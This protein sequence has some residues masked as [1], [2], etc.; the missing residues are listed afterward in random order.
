MA[1]K[2]TTAPWQPQQ[3]PIKYGLSEAERLY[4]TGKPT[5]YA[6]QTLAGF[7]PAEKR[8]QQAISGYAMGPETQAL[9][10]V[11]LLTQIP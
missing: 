7:T 9:Q 1:K 5:Y 11:L 8:A 3:D 4:D 2:T 10:A 6:G